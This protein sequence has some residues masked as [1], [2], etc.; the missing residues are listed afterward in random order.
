MQFNLP[1]TKEQMYV[2]LNDL[3]YYY[4]IRREGYED[5]NLKELDLTRLDYTPETDEEI[6]EKA[7]V[8]LSSEHQREIDKYVLDIKNQL[9]EL[10]I[11]RNLIANNALYEIDEVE[12]LFSDSV[13][14][15]Q[16]QAIKA[17]L[18][19]SSVVVDKTAA[20]ESDKNLKIADITA[21]KNEKLL[22]ISATETALK[23]KLAESETYFQ[24]A[25]EKDVQKK[26]CELM[27]KREQTLRE[28]FKYNNGLD[29]K[30]QRYANTIKQVS[31][32][33]KLRFLTI[34]AGEFTKDQLI[35]MGYYTDVIRCVSGYYDTLEPLA[36]YQDISAEKKLA[37]Y[38]DEYYQNIIYIYR[39]G[40]GY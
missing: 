1:T 4:R 18:I 33:L 40:A 14:K 9:E 11:K 6:V 7:R 3:F 39:L 23:N 32:S 25:H 37:I 20:L 19:G 29:E 22:D 15:I 28:V 21:K 36:A 5:L 12:K 30:E 26:A 27:E 2:I 38:L 13:E 17:G 24:L 10:S 8:L 34:T 16:N 35:D 31:S